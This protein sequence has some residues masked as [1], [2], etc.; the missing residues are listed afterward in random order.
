VSL[1][2]DVNVNEERQCPRNKNDAPDICQ[3]QEL[4][5]LTGKSSL[6]CKRKASA[7][8]STLVLMLYKCRSI[9]CHL[10]SM[11]TE[12]AQHSFRDAWTSYPS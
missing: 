6:W 10:Q 5:L 4:A 8:L 7:Y 9:F 1:N 11:A 2:Q 3:K 12:R